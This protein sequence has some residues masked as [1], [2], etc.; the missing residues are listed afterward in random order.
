[1]RKNQRI[2]GPFYPSHTLSSLAEHQNDQQLN[3]WCEEIDERHHHQ[4]RHDPC[5]DRRSKIM[6]TAP[7]TFIH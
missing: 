5:R 2:Y 7:T 3:A 4:T 6:K 1:M